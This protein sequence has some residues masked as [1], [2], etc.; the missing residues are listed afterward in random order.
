MAKNSQIQGT[1]VLQATVGA[2]GR[3]MNLKAISGPALLYQAALDA[4]RQ[5]VYRPFEVMGEP[6]TIQMEIKVIFSLG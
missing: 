3:P 1:V 6:R 2:D 5:W 4:V